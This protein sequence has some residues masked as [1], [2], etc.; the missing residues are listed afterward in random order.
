M[1]RLARRLWILLLLGLATGCPHS[2]GRGGMVDRVMRKELKRYLAQNNCPLDTE[3][4]YE[5]C[6]ERENQEECPAQCRLPAGEE[7]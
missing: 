6:S 7:L 1:L 4:W 3:D 5:L 2:W